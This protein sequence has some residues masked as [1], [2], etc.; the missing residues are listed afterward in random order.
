[1]DELACYEVH[2][3]K[4][5]IFFGTLFSAVALL[6]RVFQTVDAAIDLLP[7]N[8]FLVTF[9]DLEWAL[10]YR[11]LF[12]AAHACVG[13]GAFLIGRREATLQFKVLTAL[14]FCELITIYVTTFL[15]WRNDLSIPL[16]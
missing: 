5:V 7:V 12:L 14:L 1:M 8:E 11:A 9:V 3:V 4:R 2:M 15:F 16:Y 13:G 10:W 6:P